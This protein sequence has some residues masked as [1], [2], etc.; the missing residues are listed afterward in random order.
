M[1]IPVIMLTDQNTL[2]EEVQGLSSGANAYLTKPVEPDALLG[3]IEFIL[4]GR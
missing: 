4:R 1:F 3:R 2:E